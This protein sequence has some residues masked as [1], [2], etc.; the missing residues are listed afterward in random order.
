MK[1]LMKFENKQVRSHWDAEEEKWYFSIVDVIAVLTDSVDPTAYWRKLKQRLKAE[2]NESVTNC[3]A[4]KM[5]A[6]DGKMRM[7]DVADTEQ[8][9]RLIQSVPSPKAEPFK[10][11]LAKVGSQRLDQIQDPELSIQQALQDYRRLGY[12]DDWINQRLKSIEIRKEL[13]D[14]WQRTGITD[15]KDF[16]VL[17]NILTK[18]WSGK[19]VKEYKQHKGLKKQNLRDNMTSTELI[20]NMLAEASTKDISQANNPNTF[21]QSMT[22]AKQGGN[23]A[24]VAREE[25]ERQTGK[26][27]IS[28]DNAATLRRLTQNTQHDEE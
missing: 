22:I 21:N 25:L 12:S 23:V 26:S 27:V 5:R 10:Q 16:A 15:N 24:K 4:L 3:H 1:D 14:E 6:A 13:T 8:L 17:T 20:L 9:L 19:T 28:S 7:T 11:W 2:G 18:T